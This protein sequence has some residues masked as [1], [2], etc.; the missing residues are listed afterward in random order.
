M[1]LLYAFFGWSHLKMRVSSPVV[2][3][4]RGVLAS[5][6]LGEVLC[7]VA[8]RPQAPSPSPRSREA[9]E[10]ETDAPPWKE[11]EYAGDADAC[12]LMCKVCLERSNVSLL[13]VRFFLE[14]ALLH[15]WGCRDPAVPQEALDVTVLT[16][17]SH[18]HGAETR[19]SSGASL[20]AVVAL[21][22]PRVS[23]VCH[24]RNRAPTCAGEASAMQRCMVR[25]PSGP[26]R[27]EVLASFLPW[28]HG[29]FGVFSNGILTHPLRLGLV[30]A[31]WG[32]TVMSRQQY[33]PPFVRAEQL[34]DRWSQPP[35]R[36]CSLE[37]SS[38][39]LS[40]EREQQFLLG[41]LGEVP[42]VILVSG[43]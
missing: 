24:C 29:P 6:E 15:A 22:L 40:L 9:L 5:R 16:R 7:T 41:N 42:V 10:R 14:T 32:R 19:A 4:S 35:S 8:T 13:P 34:R 17:D 28:R 31:F 23:K 30:V 18:R 21:W 11:T 37:V 3:V 36:R 27:G 39:L 12:M 38:G 2:S 25:S 26:S 20:E 33:V 1:L 43:V